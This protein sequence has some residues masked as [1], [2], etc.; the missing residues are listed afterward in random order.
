MAGDN[1]S[2]APPNTLFVPVRDGVAGELA[3]A[4]TS[5]NDRGTVITPSLRLVRRNCI[6]NRG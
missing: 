2:V 6:A 3:Q 5:F 4:C 1:D